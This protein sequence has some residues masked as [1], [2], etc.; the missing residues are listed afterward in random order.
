MK[1]IKK[2]KVGIYGIVC[3]MFIG[4]YKVFGRTVA[5]NSQPKVI[6]R[7]SQSQPIVSKILYFYNIY[8]N[9]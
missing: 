4:L 5:E 6:F 3:V 7:S 1:S 2:Y 8:E 9:S